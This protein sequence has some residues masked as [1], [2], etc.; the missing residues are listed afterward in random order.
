M[1]LTVKKNNAIIHISNAI[2]GFERR[3]YNVLLSLAQAGLQNGK[4][5]FSCAIS[6]VTEPLEF[7]IR[8]IEY[9]RKSLSML[10]QTTVEFNLLDRDKIHWEAAPL[11]AYAAIKDSQIHWEYSSFMAQHLGRPNNYTILPLLEMNQLDSKYT[12]ALYELVKSYMNIGQTAPITIEML[13]TLMGVQYDEYKDFQKFVLK[14]A[15]REMAL[16]TGISVEE[17]PVKRGRKVVALKF[18]VRETPL[19]ASPAKLPKTT[20]GSGKGKKNVPSAAPVAKDYDALLRTLPQE[21]QLQII[22][23]AEYLSHL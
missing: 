1:K 20:K 18:L 17:K 6:E 3:L 2:T 23:Q 8:N 13:Q 14:P 19:V 7:D 9:I 21:T 22:K 4:T 12:I 16:K 15:I 10:I 11:L 5:K